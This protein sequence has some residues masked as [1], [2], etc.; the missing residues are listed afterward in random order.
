[1]F[2]CDRISSCCPLPL[3]LLL[4]QSAVCLAARWYMMWRRPLA[5]VDWDDP[6]Q[7]PGR[8]QK[9]ETNC[10]SSF[11]HNVTQFLAVV[12][13]L[14]DKIYFSAQ[15]W[16]Y[17]TFSWTKPVFEFVIPHITYVLEGKVANSPIATIVL[18][19]P[20]SIGALIAQGS[21]NC[22][23]HC[24]YGRYFSGNLFVL[25]IDQ[26]MDIFRDPSKFWHCGRLGFGKVILSGRHFHLAARV[27]LLSI[28]AQPP[29]I[30]YITNIMDHPPTL[31]IFIIF[32]SNYQRIEP[33]WGQQRK[34][35]KR[36]SVFDLINIEP[37]GK[38]IEVVEV[39]ARP[40]PG[41]V[42]WS[43]WEYWSS[44]LPP[45]LFLIHPSISLPTSTLNP[46]HTFQHTTLSML[47]FRT[48]S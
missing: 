42:S 20:P 39:L 23:Q 31:F 40:D 32:M 4:L 37:D 17:L 24:Q 15:T 25:D 9:K 14:V 38:P 47:L 21:V 11:L 36:S 18:P 43:H 22:H 33:G 5:Q 45:L 48:P 46:F 34:K 27:L 16:S 26:D 13:V 30:E 10:M 35:P 29:Q 6:S 2:K 28:G 7:R 12:S 1:M 41:W 19:P 44:H 8:A 3:S